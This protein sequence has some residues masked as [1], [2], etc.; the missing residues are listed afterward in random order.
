MPIPKPNSRESEKDFL[1]RCML[2]DKMIS[3]YEQQ[4]RAAVC[5]STY[6]EH[7]AGEKIS[8][9]YDDTLSTKKGY[10][11]A[12]SLIKDGNTLYVISARNDKE[13]LMRELYDDAT[14]TLIIPASR[15]YAT[16]SNKA[17]VEKVKELG[18]T[19]HYDNNADVVKELGEVGVLFT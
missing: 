2:D 6:Q 12:K 8:F 14:D 16:G 19:K 10:E 15:I 4:Q 11:L 13:K 7:L 1:Q 18:I 9:D 5:R 17:K 3:E